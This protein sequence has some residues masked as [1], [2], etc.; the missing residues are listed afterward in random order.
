MRTKK[1]LF[2]IVGGA[3]AIV[4]ILTALVF[5]S[6]GTRIVQQRLG[7]YQ[8][9]ARALQRRLMAGDFGNLTTEQ[10][11]PGGW[12]Y[13]IRG[14]ASSEISRRLFLWSTLALVTNA[15]GRSS[16]EYKPSPLVGRQYLYSAP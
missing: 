15:D 14:D 7:P 4:L 3:I 12:K 16:W 5:P 13:R 6:A 11:L 10:I 1:H 8:T 9:E 2:P